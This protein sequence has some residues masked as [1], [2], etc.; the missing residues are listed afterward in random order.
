MAKIERRVALVTVILPFLAFIAAIILFWGSIVHPADLLVCGIMYVVT[1]LGVTMGFHRLFTHRSFKCVRPVAAS[2]GIAGCMAAQGPILFWT[3]CHRRHHQFSDD[4]GDPHSPHHGFGSG[5]IST[6]R[7]WWHAH[8]AWMLTHEPED[9][10]RLTGDL[11]R[12]RLVMTI[13][14]Y[15]LV[16]VALGLIIPGVL[17]W[18]LTQTVTGFFTGMLWGGLVRMF[19]VHHT[20]WSVNSVCHIFG[21]SP[22]PTGDQSRNNAACALVTFGEGW[23]N[24]HHA[25]PSSARHGLLRGQ[26]DMVYI[27]I[28][29]LKFCRLAWDVRVPTHREIEEQR[30][31]HLAAAVAQQP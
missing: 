21:S 7:G 6:L 11:I 9:Y 23:H 25:F 12:D 26:L 3:A 31:S 24:N 18:L 8:T 20:T 5:F 10:R 1:G 15:Y 17:G 16:W 22:F 27:A 13:N 30:K 28:R 4:H 29:L 19:L 2:L 14:R